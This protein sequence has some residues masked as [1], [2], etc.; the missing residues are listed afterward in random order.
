MAEHTTKV[1]VGIVGGGPAGLMTAIL[2]KRRGITA[3][4]VERRSKDEIHKTQRAGI[5]EAGTVQML[6][7][8]DIDSRVLTE[9]HE[10]PGTVL[11]FEGVQHRIDFQELVGRS[12]W[13]YPQNEVFLDLATAWEREGGQINWSVSDTAVEGIDAD[14][15]TITFVDEH[16]SPEGIEAKLIVGADGSRSRCR[17][18]IPDDARTDYFT[19]YPFAWF[20]ILCE[21]PP[22]HQS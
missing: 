3:A 13:L 21:A 10:H 15:P 5:L 14:A 20:G 12:V 6:V 19:V 22:P 2:L 7:D 8:A 4:V 1:D 16:G 17:K 18:L 11:S 9:G